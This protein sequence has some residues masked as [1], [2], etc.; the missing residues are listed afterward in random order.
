MES[1]QSIKTHCCENIGKGR[2]FL[3]WAVEEEQS[4]FTG[5]INEKR[6]VTRS[7][8]HDIGKQNGIIK[9]ISF[10]NFNCISK[11]L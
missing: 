6:D 8:S 1:Q 3:F 2:K 4:I 11:L 5:Q 7:L 10:F 9:L